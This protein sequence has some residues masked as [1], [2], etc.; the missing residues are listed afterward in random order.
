MHMTLVGLKGSVTA[1]AFKSSEKWCALPA[2]T[3]LR[4]V[5]GLHPNLYMSKPFL[6]WHMNR[7]LS[8]GAMQLCC[9]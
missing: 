4:L 7:L 1:I 3:I 8:P 5:L 6:W 9:F 2:L